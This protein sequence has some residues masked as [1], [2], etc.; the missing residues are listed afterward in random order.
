MRRSRKPIVIASRTSRLARVQAETVA[1]A[2]RRLH[3]Q[4]EVEFHWIVSEGD[5]VTEGSLAEVGGKGLFTRGV[6]RAVADGLADVAV[7]SLKDLPVDPAESIPGLV[8]AAVPRRAPVFDCLV[9]SGPYHSLR[10]LPADAVVGTSSPRRAAQLR[11]VRGDLDV[12]LLRGNVDTRLKKVLAPGGPYAAA[13]LAQAGLKRLKLHEHADRPLP[14]EQ[15][16]PAASQGAIGLRCRATDHVTLT[17]CLPLNSAASSTAV[18]HERELVRLLDADC[19][20]PIAVLVEPIDPAETRAK[21]NADSHWSR[22]RARVCSAD[23][24][25]VLEVDVQCKTGELRRRVKAVAKQLRDDGAAELLRDAA[26]AKI[27][28]LEGKGPSVANPQQDRDGEASPRAAESD[29][30]AEAA[31][32]QGHPAA[33]AQRVNISVTAE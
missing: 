18:M 25:R 28:M 4:V 2:L 27:P 29:V 14:L 7:H 16:L 17:R 26:G 1:K 15:M 9:T 33:R 31:R 10:E 22:L 5:K 19:Y 21:R 32:R 20:S 11:S 12:R 24:Q 30:N 3:P 13:L 6:D 8:L 23:G